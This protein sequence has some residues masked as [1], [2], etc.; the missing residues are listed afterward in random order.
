MPYET[1]H[2]AHV[3]EVNFGATAISEDIFRWI[4]RDF[5]KIADDLADTGCLV[6]N[7]VIEQKPI[8]SNSKFFRVFFD[9]SAQNGK[10]GGGWCLEQAWS[11]EGG[12]PLWQAALKVAIHIKPRSLQ[13]FAIT[14]ETIACFEAMQAI[15]TAVDLGY[16]TLSP[17]CRVV[18]KGRLA[19]L[20]TEPV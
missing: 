3:A 4:P 6:G 17:R 10:I 11:I 19:E 20:D 15:L 1:S 9:G 14:A 13:A 5:N 2:D 7:R 12:Y 16:V 18:R 8:R